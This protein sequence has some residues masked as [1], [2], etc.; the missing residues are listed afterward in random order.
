MV[1]GGRGGKGAGCGEW[2]GPPRAVD[3]HRNVYSGGRRRWSLVT[4]RWSLVTGYRSL[5]TGH[6]S[7][8]TGHLVPGPWT[9]PLFVDWSIV[10]TDVVSSLRSEGFYQCSGGHWVHRCYIL[11]EHHDHHEI[12]VVIRLFH[13]DMVLNS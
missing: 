1:G 4:G 7:L 11:C 6:W 13:N 3:F 12:G 2:N 5:V 8:V 9:R 10:N